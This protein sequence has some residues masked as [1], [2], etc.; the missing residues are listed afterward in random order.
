M[1]NVWEEKHILPR[2]YGFRQFLPNSP[3]T[4][5]TFTH[6]GFLEGVQG[7]G[8]SSIEFGQV[9]QAGCVCTPER[10]TK[11]QLPPPA[12]PQ[13]LSPNQNI[14]VV[15]LSLTLQTPPHPTPKIHPVKSMI[16]LPS[17]ESNDIHQ[18]RIPAVKRRS[19]LLFKPTLNTLCF[20]LLF[21]RFTF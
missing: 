8:L 13:Y 21:L 5:S 3:S 10:A 9:L 2:E 12:H 4:C 16:K 1:G 15:H 20:S 17:E 18:Y 7:I 11:V 19:S 6:N 14:N